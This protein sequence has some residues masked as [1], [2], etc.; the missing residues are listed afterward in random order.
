MNV[1]SAAKVLDV[2]DL[3]SYDAGYAAGYLDGKTYG[4]DT[5]RKDYRKKAREHKQH[6]DAMRRRRLYFLK[7]KLIGVF[8]LVITIFMTWILDGDAT[9]AILTVPI[10]LLLIF[11]KKKYWIGR[12]Y[13]QM[14]ERT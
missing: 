7:Q 11:S 6:R 12:D 14:E 2:I 13:F 10:S 1:G 4:Y 8:L 5:C 3:Q 9:M